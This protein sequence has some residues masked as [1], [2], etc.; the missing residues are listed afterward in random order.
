MEQQV[1]TGNLEEHWII[2]RFTERIAHYAVSHFHRSRPFSLI[3]VAML[4]IALDK[5]LALGVDADVRTTLIGAA[6]VSRQ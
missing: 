1:T 3:D 6:E 5:S 4:G 2:A